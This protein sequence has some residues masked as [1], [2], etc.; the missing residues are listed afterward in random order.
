V[1]LLLAR[2]TNELDLGVPTA[3]EVKNFAIMNFKNL[4]LFST[5]KNQS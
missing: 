3:C 1:K 2:A 5:S 4:G